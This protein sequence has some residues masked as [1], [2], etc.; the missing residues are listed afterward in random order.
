MTIPGVTGRSTSAAPLGIVQRASWRRGLLLACLGSASVLVLSGSQAAATVT[1]YQGLNNGDWSLGANWT[2]IPNNAVPNAT[3]DANIGN[4][5]NTVKLSTAST[6]QSL[7]T[8]SSTGSI[9]LNGNTLTLSGTVTNVFA[10]TIKN[11]SAPGSTLTVLGSTTPAQTLS[12]VVSGATSIIVNGGQLRLSNAANT[13]TGGITVGGNLFAFSDGAL[14]NSANSV[15][16]GPA[17]TTGQLTWNNGASTVT[18]ARSIAVGAAGGQIF[19]NGTAAVTM[20]GAVTGAGPLT[21][22][23]TGSL[24]LNGAIGNTGLLRVTGG[25]LTVNGVIGSSVT[26][27]TVSGGSADL[28]NVSNAYVGTNTVSGGSTLIVDSTA[29]NAD[30]V[31]GAATNGIT[32]GSTATSS[33]GTLQWSN[34]GTAEL[35][36]RAVTL[37]GTGG[38]INT[39]G[40]A[41]V[42][43][44]GNVAGTSGLTKSGIGSLT[45][46][47]ALSQTG[48]LSVT[49][50]TLNLTHANS[51]TGGTTVS[52]GTLNTTGSGTLGST[53]STVTVSGGTLNVGT[54]SQ[55]VGTLALTGGALTDNGSVTVG[56]DYT[57]T[58][59]GSGN[60]FNARANVTGTGVINAGGNTA[61]AVVGTGVTNGSANTATL[62]LGTIHVGQT[63]TQN[64]QVTNTGTVAGNAAKLRGAIETSGI[65]SSNLAASAT[66]FVLAAGAT[67]ANEAVN[68]T[69]NTRGAL[70]SQS[71]IVANN[72]ANVQNGSQTVAITGQ[73]ND[74]A[75]PVFQKTSGGGSFSGSGSS[76]T[77]DFGT[78][79]QHASVATAI[80]D[81]LNQLSTGGSTEFTDL[82]DGSFTLGTGPF[83]LGNFASF[84]GVAGN[85]E[86]SNLSVA[87][88]TSGVGTFDE[89]ITLSSSSRNSSGTT[90]LAPVT[91]DLTGTVTGSVAVPEPGMLATFGAS[92]GFL[93][94]VRRRHR[95]DNTNA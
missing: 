87:F 9:D 49:A 88:D 69:G 59:F 95:L 43:M 57:N 34:G 74:F 91:L 6:A 54:T 73:V 15:L 51:Y 38:A 3:T 52:A 80:L 45:L 25:A 56:S 50:G 72:F 89:K 42:T 70:T 13:F 90:D 66:D 8:G 28:T 5:T 36:A 16:L 7:V 47:G 82:L 40:S 86:W 14:G 81:I 46:S 24:N 10:G 68:F 60:G 58:G 62:S 18:S 79:G 37:A 83:S 41:L 21:K 64:I 33:S 27:L 44:S 20:S 75:T 22:S 2:G 17:T 94:F 53:S 32:L 48:G 11:T 93:A 77:L 1:T 31:L 61:Q 84:N 92:L 26:G 23:G 67:S 30:H 71:L 65:T 35:S 55:T 76:Y 78:V 29:A 85:S 4:N 12:G 63:A 39:A 19:E